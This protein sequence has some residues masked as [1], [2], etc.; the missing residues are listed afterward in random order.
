MP[1]TYAVHS[2]SAA[3]QHVSISSSFD[4]SEAM[5]GQLNAHTRPRES[6][7]LH[8]ALVRPFAMRRLV[9]ILGPAAGLLACI[10]PRES[11]TIDSV[12]LPPVPETTSSNRVPSPATAVADT[13][14]RSV[15]APVDS[16]QFRSIYEKPLNDTLTLTLS[17]AVRERD[18]YE[19]ELRVSL[20]P[21][22]M[23]QQARIIAQLQD[24]Y[25]DTYEVLRADDTSVVIGRNGLWNSM[26]S[27]K[28]FLHPQSKAVVK[29]I[30]YGPGIGLTA[31]DD[32][33][34]ARLLDVSSEI[35]EQLK[36]KP[37]P[38]IPDSTHMPAEFRRHPMPQ[39]TYDEFAQA[40]PVR[41]T[42]GYRRDDTVLEEEPGP[43][44]I[45]GSR[46]WFGKT[47]YD[48]E[49][50]SGV[51]GLG[52]FDTTTSQYAFLPVSGLADWSVS[53][54]L[55][56]EDAAWIGL[57]DH[58]EGEDNGG[59]LIRYDFKSG[60]SRRFLTEELVHHIV[61][62]KDRVY[63]ATINGAYVLQGNRLVKRYRVEPDIDNRFILVSENLPPNP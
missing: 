38:E 36:K 48:G 51:G 47:F 59:G 24:R 5:V 2:P 34:V 44:Q 39:S 16:V 54:V 50:T 9:F 8:T 32:T 15:E 7:W 46:I 63:V 26:P 49:G 3:L 62:W 29:Q 18:H 60:T 28:L 40:R 21:R 56:E 42:N 33:E 53:A 11:A 55:V 4:C 10:Q 1:H 57:V 13:M 52:Y 22:E 12:A 58:G 35:V 31:V 41:V 14:P 45:A 17:A 25:M 37:W 61:R 23:P 6:S 30:D 20:I 43:Y 19:L 27:R